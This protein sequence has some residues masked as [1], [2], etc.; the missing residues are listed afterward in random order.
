MAF[1]SLLSESLKR[2]S[3]RRVRIKTDPALV[4]RNE[5]F[6]KIEG[7]EGY[8]LGESKLGLKVLVLN[9]EMTISDVPEEVLEIISHQGNIDMVNEFK[10]Y[11]K[12]CLKE[13]KQKSDNDPVFAQIDS[14]N[15][16]EDIESFIKQG[17]LTEGELNNLYRGFLNDE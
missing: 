12:K 13:L 6:R 16:I 1:H 9:P 14:A 5:D 8:I 10:C 11:A 4:A 7:Y 2:T 3:L 17:G 15:S